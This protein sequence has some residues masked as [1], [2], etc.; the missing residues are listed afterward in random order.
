MAEFYS[1]HNHVNSLALKQTANPD[2]FEGLSIA[3]LK[4][5]VIFRKKPQGFLLWTKA[6]LACVPA[7][8]KYLSQLLSAISDCGNCPFTFQLW[9]SWAI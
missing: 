8:L 4:S 1:L 9:V 3:E 2:L 5:Y 6:F 7:L